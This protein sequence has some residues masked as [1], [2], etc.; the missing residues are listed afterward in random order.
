MGRRPRPTFLVLTSLTVLLSL[1]VACAPRTEPTS[2]PTGTGG[3]GTTAT[4]TGP[5]PTATPTPARPVPTPT[6][7]PTPPTE[8]PDPL[9]TYDGHPIPG[10]KRGGILTTFIERGPGTCDMAYRPQRGRVTVNTCG[11]LFNTLLRLWP[12]EQIG[13]ELA[14]RWETS[15]DGRE[16]TFHLRE[17]V[18][19]HDGTPLTAEDVAFYFNRLLSPPQGL[20]VDE[21]AFLRLGVQEVVAVDPLTVKFVLEAPAADFLETMALPRYGIGSRQAYEKLEAEGKQPLFLEYTSVV[22]TGPFKPMRYTE[23]SRYESTR[24]TDYWMKDL[25]YIDGVHILVLPDPAAR[26][27]AFLTGQADMYQATELTFSDRQ[28]LERSPRARDITVFNYTTGLRQVLWINL[29]SPLMQDIRVREA[30]LRANNVHEAKRVLGFNQGLTGGFMPPHGPWGLPAEELAQYPGQGSDPEEDL[31][32]AKQLLADA[33]YAQGL[34]LRPI[35]T[36]VTDRDQAAGTFVANR[37]ALL[38][39]EVQSRAVDAAVDT[40]EV[41]ENRNYDV[42][43]RYTGWGGDVAQNMGNFLCDATPTGNQMQY[44]NPEYDSLYRLQAQTMDPAKRREILWDMQRMLMKEHMFQVL[45]WTERN[46]A[47]WNHVKNYDPSGMGQYVH[48]A[49]WYDTLWLDK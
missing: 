19:F 1:A 32:R 46:V 29:K 28:A 5:A 48:N 15:V 37:L 45:L 34:K 6:P 13:P 16:W 38:G 23:E 7:T 40:L 2:M 35:L 3:P 42:L 26:L 4:P 36:R 25:P 33:G 18:K 10:A 43:G 21:R 49:T 39:I 20:V 11:G 22:G 24:N 8:K 44:C 27:A 41:T 47:W 12:G 30:I 9:K 14:V 17:G 31:Q